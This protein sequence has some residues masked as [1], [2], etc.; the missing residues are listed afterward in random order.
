MDGT[1]KVCPRL[2]K[3]LVTIHAMIGNKCLP[4]VF[5]LLANKTRQA[6]VGLL[7]CLKDAATTQ[8]QIPPLQL[9][10]FTTDFE[11]G[12]APAIHEEFPGVTH[13]G[14]FFHFCQ[15]VLKKV[16]ALGLQAVYQNDDDV[17]DIIR[18]LTALAFLPI[19]QVQPAFNLLHDEQ[20]ENY[21]DFAD[22]FAYF[23]DTWIHGC[24]V[25]R[26][27]VHLLGNRTNNHVEGWH[28]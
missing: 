18:S 10:L 17:R 16:Q 28:N 26:W 3:R 27:N 22:L 14:C 20:I 23:E 24:P 21:P 9:Q 13:K 7:R 4:L 5:T 12:L 11:A 1:F 25:H 2:Y 15:A 6:Y 8:E 19:E